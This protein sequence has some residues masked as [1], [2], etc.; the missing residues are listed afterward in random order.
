VLFADVTRSRE[1]RPGLNEPSSAGPESIYA[2]VSKTI[3]CL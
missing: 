3:I 2:A 1:R